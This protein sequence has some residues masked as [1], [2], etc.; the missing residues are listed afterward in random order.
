[1]GSF[2]R[3]RSPE[4]HDFF[5]QDYFEEMPPDEMV[6]IPTC[7][8]QADFRQH[9]KEAVHATHA[10]HVR[11]RRPRN[12]QMPAKPHRWHYLPHPRF[13]LLVNSGECRK[14]GVTWIYSDA[15]GKWV[16]LRRR[17]YQRILNSLSKRGFRQYGFSSFASPRFDSHIHTV[18]LF[19][20]YDPIEE[21]NDARFF[22]V[23]TCFH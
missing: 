5:P 22:W 3:I 7:W 23:Q 18:K 4:V 10:T 19:N 12:P 15:G 21:Q 20:F 2:Q 14:V 16:L 13:P 9:K 11:T 17:C 6:A 8:N 1:M